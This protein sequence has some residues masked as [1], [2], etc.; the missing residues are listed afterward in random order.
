MQVPTAVKLTVDPAI[1]HTDDALGSTVN[2]TGLPEPPPVAATSYVE[3][4]TLAPDGAVDVNTIACDA[5]TYTSTAS[6]LD[7]QDRQTATTSYE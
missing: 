6:L 5:F 7:V 3:P 1:E 2:V 4:P